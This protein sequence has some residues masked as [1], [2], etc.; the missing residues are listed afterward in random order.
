MSKGTGKVTADLILDVEPSIDLSP[1]SPT[2]FG[3][4]H[5]AS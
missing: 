1:F 3:K 4:L 5:A 2:R